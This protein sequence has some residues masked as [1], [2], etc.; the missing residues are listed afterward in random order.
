MVLD[1]SGDQTLELPLLAN[2]LESKILSPQPKYASDLYDVIQTQS[3]TPPLLIQ[4]MLAEM[5][6]P[7]P[8]VF[9]VEAIVGIKHEI[10]NGQT[11]TSYLAKW[12]GYT[13][14][15]NS[16]VY[17]KDCHCLDMIALFLNKC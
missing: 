7:P 1:I 10:V 13:E 5:P 15:E 2:V 12:V 11:V 3:P 8:E 16:W 6:T 17:A 14:E 9:D 4:K